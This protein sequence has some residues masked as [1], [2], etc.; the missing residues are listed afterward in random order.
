MRGS[1]LIEM[2]HYCPEGGGE[3]DEADWQRRRTLL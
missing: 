2:V 1:L 3:Q